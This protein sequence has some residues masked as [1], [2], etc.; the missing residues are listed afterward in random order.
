[1]GGIQRLFLIGITYGHTEFVPT[2]DPYRRE[3]IVAC[4]GEKK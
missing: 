4:P 1:V 3:S 2:A